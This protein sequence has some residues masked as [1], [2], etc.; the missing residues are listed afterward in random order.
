MTSVPATVEKVEKIE[1]ISPDGT[2]TFRVTLVFDNPGTLT[3]DMDAIGTILV[4]GESVVPA[5][6]GKL[7]YS[8]EKDIVLESSGT[9]TAV[10]GLSYYRFSA[11]QSL[12]SMSNPDVTDALESARAG[13]ESQQLTLT[14]ARPVQHL[15]CVVGNGL[16][17]HFLPQ[18]SDIPLS[19][20]TT[21]PY[22][23]RCPCFRLLLPGR[24]ADRKIVLRG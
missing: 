6:T 15:K 5:D 12:L 17:H 23:P 9:V 24:S 21:F 1:R 20:R 4:D 11:G 7:E 18:T 22:V 3:K 16:V 14:D 19:S 10:S 8:R 13:V 2:K